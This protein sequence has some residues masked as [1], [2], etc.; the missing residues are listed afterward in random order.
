MGE[1]L[2]AVVRWQ[3]TD[4]EKRYD[5]TRR[6]SRLFTLGH[7][8]SPGCAPCSSN[9]GTG[10]TAASSANAGADAAYS[11]AVA[12]GRHSIRELPVGGDHN[13]KLLD[14]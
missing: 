12:A 7:R 5:L 8:R 11:P 4:R 6:R 13:A 9:H 14:T 1:S 3:L 10:T 2:S